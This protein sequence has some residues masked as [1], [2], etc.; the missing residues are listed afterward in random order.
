ME[1]VG[2]LAGGVAHDFNNL[3]TVINSYACFA[4]EGSND[5][6]RRLNP[7]SS[8]SGH[9]KAHAAFF[10]GSCQGFGDG[11]DGLKVRFAGSHGINRPR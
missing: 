4:R 2:G 8:L 7:L 9:A 11:V 6:G 10:L 3:L 5:A 1:S